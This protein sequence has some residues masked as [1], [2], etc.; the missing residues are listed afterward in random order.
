MDIIKIIRWIWDE[1]AEGNDIWEN[2]KS[3]G[4]DSKAGTVQSGVPEVV[5]SGAG[6]QDK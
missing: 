2:G 1:A 3:Q 4:H 5:S 6:F